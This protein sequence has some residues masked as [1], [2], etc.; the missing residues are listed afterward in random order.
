MIGSFEQ[1]F[2]ASI[3]SAYDDLQNFWWNVLLVRCASSEVFLVTS[4]FQ[5]HLSSEHLFFRCFKLPSCWFHCS[6]LLF[7]N[8]CY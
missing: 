6:Y 7:Q 8:L 5:E 4:A 1:P 3:H 2:E